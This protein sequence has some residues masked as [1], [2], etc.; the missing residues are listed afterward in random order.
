MVDREHF[1][2]VNC[3]VVA[4]REALAAE[5]GRGNPENRDG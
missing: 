1:R 4:E 5:A 3:P 2:V